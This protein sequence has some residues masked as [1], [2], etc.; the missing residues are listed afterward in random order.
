MLAYILA[1]AV[2]GSS[3]FIFTKALLDQEH[4]KE[5]HLLQTDLFWGGVGLFYALVLW[6]C[7][8]RITGAVLL[9]QI[10]SVSLLGWFGWQTLTLR[11]KLS[12]SE[13]PNSPLASTTETTEVS[14]ETVNEALVTES[15]I[16]QE[17]EI[18]VP[19]VPED[20]LI[21]SSTSEERV[22]DE[23][24]VTS[25]D[26]EEVSNSETI[27]DTV[28]EEGDI[29]IDTSTTE[30]ILET[31]DNTYVDE[32][33]ELN[34]QPLEQTDLPSP[35][36]KIG[37]FLP[38]NLFNSVTSLFRKQKPTTKVTLDN[39]TQDWQGEGQ[40]TALIEDDLTTPEE[41]ETEEIANQIATEI[42]EELVEEDIAVDVKVTVEDEQE[43]EEITAEVVDVSTIEATETTTLEE[44]SV[45]GE[46]EVVRLEQEEDKVESLT[47]EESV[48]EVEST[49]ESDYQAIPP[50]PPEVD[51]VAQAQLETNVSSWEEISLEVEL[52]PPVEPV[53]DGESEIPTDFPE[54]KQP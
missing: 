19:H 52:A 51:I 21:T 33:V 14:S 44:V 37:S 18:A 25:Q 9:G 2:G 41:T 15:I 5:G 38:T 22:T 29:G 16:P 28:L 43:T 24:E 53:K 48:D 12:T 13:V 45:D 50:Q 26:E 23:V 47:P 3:L 7:A 34:Q 54:R 1:L 27:S 6:I 11:S 30:I 39:V 10:A 4:Q 17:E 35:S 20:E 49:T 40:T 36:K 46:D 42:V 31:E 8:G 32:E